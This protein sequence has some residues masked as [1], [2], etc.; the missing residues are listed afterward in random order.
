MIILQ[1]KIIITLLVLLGTS[2]IGKTKQSRLQKRNG[3]FI[4]I[5]HKNEMV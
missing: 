2:I 3:I 4:I 1:N 5:I